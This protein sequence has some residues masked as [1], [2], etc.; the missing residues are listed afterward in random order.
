MDSVFNK[1]RLPIVF[2]AVLIGLAMLMIFSFGLEQYALQQKEID[3][4]IIKIAEEQ[5]TT[6]QQILNRAFTIST[7][8]SIESRRL[9]VSDLKYLT[10]TWNEEHRKLITGSED[11]Q[12]PRDEKELVRKLFEKTN[13]HQRAIYQAVQTIV[14]CIENQFIIEA[15]CE[16]KINQAVANLYNHEQIFMGETNKIIIRLYEEDR[17]RLKMYGQEMFGLLMINLISLV[18]IGLFLFRPTAR[19]I[20]RI[21]KELETNNKK[22]ANNNQKL[23]AKDKKL[24]Q[25]VAAL[26]TTQEALRKQ[27]QVVSQQLRAIN[28]TLAFVEFSP[29]G[30]IRKANSIFLKA[31]GYSLR[32]IEGQPHLMLT[33]RQSDWH[34]RYADFWYDLQNGIA[35]NEIFKKTDKEGNEIWLDATFTPVRNAENQV[36]KVI[37]LGKDVT[38]AHHQ[39]I[40]FKQKMMAISKSTVMITV[41]M[42]GI[43]I[44]AN[45]EFVKLLGYRI[46]EIMGRHHHLLLPDENRNNFNLSWGNLLKGQFV[47]GIYPYQHKNKKTVWVNATY[48][49]ITDASGKITKI[50]IF[51]QN[52]T[53]QK[54]LEEKVLGQV[55][56]LKTQEKILRRNMEELSAVNE[57]QEAQNQLIA[58]QNLRLGEAKKQLEIQNRHVTDSIKY[59]KR[60]QEA[61][62][63]NQHELQEFFPESF[64]F[65]HPKA[66]VSGDFYRF[67]TLNYQGKLLK[68]IIVADCTGHGVS[69]AFMTVLG[70]M[71]F[72]EII[73]EQIFEPNQILYHLDRKIGLALKKY[74]NSS[75]QLKDGMD[76]AILM[77]DE[78]NQIAQFAGAKNPMLLIQDQKMKI[79][80]ASKYPIGHTTHKKLQQKT[81]ENQI[82]SFKKGDNLYL[83]SDGFQDQFGERYEMKYLRKRF[84]NFL[85]E[86]SRFPAEEQKKMLAQ[87]FTKWKGST[88]QT[89]DILII[90]LKI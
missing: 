41:N 62:L 58:E 68:I 51:A 73:N 80:K 78:A 4:H 42:D 39:T 85:M 24:L 65:F 49:P 67:Y 63:G 15:E 82:F 17:K 50:L 88:S 84:R 1:Y 13:P 44:E 20:A 9:L 75:K 2:N 43:I 54:E 35:K 38:K 16:E 36:S 56:R 28:N 77:I 34:E 8:K 81:F 32:E 57:A 37:L 30:K 25:N 89:D 79:F 7:L 64:V 61:I 48:N 74:H 76:V 46:Q 14:R 71:L 69:G 60:V 45:E 55:N 26:N 29:D 90:G 22:L 53:R 18:F 33:D 72:D 66:I 5:R 27:G 10:D 47:R 86:I 12:M 87:E 11:F 70:T 31:F 40:D 19:T 23:T 3:L 21:M 6:S 52:I 83:F 59:A